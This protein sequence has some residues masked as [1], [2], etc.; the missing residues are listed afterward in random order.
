M[1]GGSSTWSGI[2]SDEIPVL[3]NSVT[4]QFSCSTCSKF[5]GASFC[6]NA[7][8]KGSIMYVGAISVAIYPNDMYER[9]LDKI[10]YENESIGE[11]FKKAYYDHS[12]PY[13]YI[14]M[15]SVL[16][17]PTLNINPSYTLNHEVKYFLLNDMFWV[18]K[19]V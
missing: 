7:V 3:N 8:R 15:T 13:S 18:P 2:D 12:H 9:V 10:Y 4:I 19:K 14:S 6:N 5:D 11:S 16:G 17:D 1:C